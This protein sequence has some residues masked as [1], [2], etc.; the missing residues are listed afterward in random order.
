MAQ[1]PVPDPNAKSQGRQAAKIQQGNPD[2]SHHVGILLLLSTF[3]LEPAI[4]QGDGSGRPALLDRRKSSQPASNL[5]YCCGPM[6][7]CAKSAARTATSSLK[8]DAKS[9]PRC[10]PR[11]RPM[12]NN[13]RH[14]PRK[15]SSQKRTMSWDSTAETPKKRNREKYRR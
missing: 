1:A 7:C 9:S 4:R 12:S 5:G 15:K 6:D 13:S 10:W 11:V 3:L 14:L 8:A 2:R